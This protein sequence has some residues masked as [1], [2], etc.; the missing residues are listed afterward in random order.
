MNVAKNGF[1]AE[2]AGAVMG[3][4]GILKESAKNAAAG[5]AGAARDLGSWVA[6]KTGLTN[7]GNAMVSANNA[8]QAFGYGDAGG[9]RTQADL[10]AE[11]A[12]AGGEKALSAALMVSPIGPEALAAGAVAMSVKVVGQATVKVVGAAIPKVSNLKLSNI[13]SDLYK[14]ARGSTPIGTG[15]TADAIRNEIGTG[16]ATGGRFHT[17]KGTEYIRALENWQAKNPNASHYDRM[18]AESLKNDLRNAIGK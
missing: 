6:D 13:V 18:V 10:A 8:A 17:Q 14:G 11:Q 9:G 7:I 1:T 15:S 3:A 5:V 4:V 16:L 12:Q 2:S